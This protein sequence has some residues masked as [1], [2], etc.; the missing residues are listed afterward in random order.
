[1]GHSTFDP[2]EVGPTENKGRKRGA[3]RPLKPKE[4]WAIRFMFDQSV[5][6]RGRA[7]QHPGMVR[8]MRR[9]LRR[10]LP[11]KGPLPSFDHLEELFDAIQVMLRRHPQ[12]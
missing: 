11:F 5:R 12:A 2:I 10:S 1:M 3:K 6:L 7:I 4:I 9:R 8:T